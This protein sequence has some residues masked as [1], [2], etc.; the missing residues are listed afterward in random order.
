MS[1]FPIHLRKNE[2]LH[3]ATQYE[4]RAAIES[5]YDAP[6]QPWKGIQIN[7]CSVC[8]G[9]GLG[10]YNHDNPE[11]TDSLFSQELVNP[12]TGAYAETLNG[13]ERFNTYD[14]TLNSYE[15][16]NPMGDRNPKTLYYIDT[17]DLDED[18]NEIIRDIEKEFTTEWTGIAFCLR[19]NGAGSETVLPHWARPR[20]KLTAK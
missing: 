10:R 7:N 9:T 18:G 11:E 15:R 12:K 19:C 4:Q 13:Y 6:F 8:N 1:A 16:F 17:G 3:D 5:C 20:A 2:V 14:E